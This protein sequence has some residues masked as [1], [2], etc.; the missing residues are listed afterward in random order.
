[1]KRSLS[2]PDLHNWRINEVN[3]VFRVAII[4]Y[5]NPFLAMEVFKFVPRIANMLADDGT[6]DGFDL[7]KHYFEQYFMNVKK[8]KR[9]FGFEK[10][11]RRSFMWLWMYFRKATNI[12]IQNNNYRAHSK[13][14]YEGL[15]IIA[16]RHCKWEREKSSMYCDTP[17]MIDLFLNNEK[18]ENQ[19]NLFYPIEF[20]NIYI[21][22][23]NDKIKR[24]FYELDL[25]VFH[26]CIHVGIEIMFELGVFTELLMMKPDHVT[27][28]EFVFK[29]FQLTKQ[30]ETFV[31]KGNIEERFKIITSTYP[32]H[33]DGITTGIYLG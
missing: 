10:S 5:M 30:I 4:R 12:Y 6:P 31:L 21:K 19:K 26:I 28:R 25:T 9:N 8:G 27:E 1:M 33:P 14:L 20:T 3:E 13:S 22:E 16:L 2:S 29:Y 32:K 7:W 24:M 11:Y 17:C 23:T 15:N 18:C